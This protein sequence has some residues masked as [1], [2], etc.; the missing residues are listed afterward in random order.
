ME[1]NEVSRKFAD[2]VI[3]VAI[4]LKYG[5]FDKLENM[6]DSEVEVICFRKGTTYCRD[7]TKKCDHNSVQIWNSPFCIIELSDYFDGEINAK[8]YL[9]DN[10]LDMRNIEVV[11][12][13]DYLVIYTKGA[14]D[15]EVDLKII[16]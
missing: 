4:A 1:L 5:K 9:G 12:D 10:I 2:V 15:I 13:D 8:M 7:I 14:F 3:G 16:D 6:K 11:T